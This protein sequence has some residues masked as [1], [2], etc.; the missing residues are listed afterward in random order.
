MFPRFLGIGAQ[1]CGTSWLHVNLR[2][3]PQ[4][5]LPP[6]KEIHF[7]D[8][9][10]LPIREQFN[11]Y[12]VKRPLGM[13]LRGRL[14]KDLRRGQWDRVGWHANYFLRPRTEAWYG[15]L[16]PDSTAAIP[17]D[18][19]PIYGT[20]DGDQVRRVAELVPGARLIFLMREPV[21]R[22]WSELRMA[23]RLRVGG[24]RGCP[25]DSLEDV[26]V[27]D[28]IREAD[29]GGMLISADY[30][31]QLGTW[32]A[33]FPAQ[34][35][36]VGFL[37]EIREDPSLFLSRVCSFLGVDPSVAWP[38]A[39]QARHEGAPVPLP[40]ALAAYLAERERPMLARLRQRLSELGVTRYPPWVGR[41]VP[42]RSGV[43]QMARRTTSSA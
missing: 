7:F 21:S 40:G 15:S 8:T 11:H 34:Q 31:R 3:H 36:F 10:D 17:G 38:E 29:S 23:H 2:Q 26:P 20:L 14:G 1:K 42:F 19:T 32:A 33:H 5:W 35:L 25:W 37:D 12:S 4:I 16:F 41:D 6:K 22:I 13:Y 39:K 43:G 18:I 27:P 30:A 24:F 9:R 28:L